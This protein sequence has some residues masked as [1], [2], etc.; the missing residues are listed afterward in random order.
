VILGPAP[1]LDPNAADSSIGPVECALTLARLRAVGA[2]GDLTSCLLVGLGHRQGPADRLARCLEHWRVE[3]PQDGTRLVPGR[4]GLRRTSVPG[5][6]TLVLGGSASG[7]SALAED[8]LAA[9]PEVLYTATGPVVDLRTA[10]DLEWEH[11]VRR[12]RER[13]PA[14]WR[15]EETHLV[16]GL[17]AKVE[18]PILLDSIGTWLTGVL[19]RSG[20][21]S[22]AAGWRERVA[23]ETDALVQAWRAR[24]TGLVAVSD[25]V[26]LSIVPATPGGRLFRDELGHLNRR[27]ADE[28]EQ[29]L[30]VVAG[31]LLTSP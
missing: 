22:E 19:D 20:A 13:R 18:E 23:D 5:G 31:R 30:I 11:R 26:G 25:E 27:L 7:K 29:V 14:W 28:S 3:A 15:T 24:R 10:P 6:R 1:D 9:E 4:P 2:V 16:A 21:W 12:H 8:L 17:L